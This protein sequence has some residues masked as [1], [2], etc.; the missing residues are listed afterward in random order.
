M[1]GHGETVHQFLSHHLSCVV[2]NRAYCSRSYTG[3]RK[4]Y[5]EGRR[6]VASS[7]R[8]KAP[9]PSA[10]LHLQNR[11]SALVAAEGPGAQSSKAVAPV[12]PDPT[13]FLLENHQRRERKDLRRTGQ[14]LQITSWHRAT[15]MNNTDLFFTKIGPYLRVNCC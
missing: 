10:D 5:D 11:L 15:G 2:K 13:C 3:G 9:A 8:R 4:N 1:G 7:N 12:E 14:I 6:L